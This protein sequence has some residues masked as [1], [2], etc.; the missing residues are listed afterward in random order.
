MQE[1]SPQIL[2]LQTLS[3]H[4]TVN[5]KTRYLDFTNKQPVRTRHSVELCMPP[6]DDDEL[7]QTL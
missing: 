6:A 7:F 5:Q 1:M 2:A 3:L 4:K